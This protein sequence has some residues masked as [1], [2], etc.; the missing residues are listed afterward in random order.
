MPQNLSAQFVCP[1]PKVLDFNEKRLHWASVVHG[2]DVHKYM[3]LFHKL[4]TL[5]WPK[6]ACCVNALDKNGSLQDLYKITL[7]RTLERYLCRIRNGQMRNS[8]N[9]VKTSSTEVS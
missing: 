3:V 6:C 9:Q 2:K 1:N 7:P 8:F 4:P 5:C